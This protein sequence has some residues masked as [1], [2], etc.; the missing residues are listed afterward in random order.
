MHDRSHTG[1]S[2]LQRTTLDF[3]TVAQLGLGG[4]FWLGFLC[5]L[6]ASTVSVGLPVALHELGA[7]GA[8]P[9]QPQLA[10]R[11][12]LGTQKVLRDTARGRR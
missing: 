1:A 6:A 11:T 12:P 7:G 5:L 2:T 4:G 3:W 10:A 9:P 8:A